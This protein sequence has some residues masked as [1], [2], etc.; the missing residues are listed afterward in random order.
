M[1]VKSLIPWL[2]GDGVLVL[3][4]TIPRHTQRLYDLLQPALLSSE[5]FER[6]K[7]A[8]EAIKEGEQIEKIQP[9][10]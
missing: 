8:E 3:A 4:E 1:I 5:L 10:V 9:I 6:L 2:S 7:L